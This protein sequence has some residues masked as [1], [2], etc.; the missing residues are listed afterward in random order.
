MIA[1]ENIQLLVVGICIVG[2]LLYIVYTNQKSAPPSNVEGFVTL[3]DSDVTINMCPAGTQAVQSKN[4]DT[5]CCDGEIADFKCK[6]KL[7]CSL[8]PAHDGLASCLEA[9]RAGL[10]AKGT[11]ICPSSMPRYFENLRAGTAGCTSGSR[12]ADGTDVLD[13]NQ[14]K[15]TVYKTDRENRNTVDS[16]Y[17]QKLLE[18]Y[19][20]PTYP[21]KTSTKELTQ[22]GAP[23]SVPV[24]ISCKIQGDMNMTDFCVDDTTAKTYLNETN[25]SW[26]SW[27]DSN[28]SIKRVFC[29]VFQQLR[30]D[31]TITEAQ[32]KDVQI[33]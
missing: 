17:N 13:M 15:C 14:K 25:T 32:L 28:P 26:R 11:S 2:I 3:D 7:M 33:P 24:Y 16:C 5:D 1:K 20:C 23:G 31:K 10:R 19:Q 22:W 4:G 18:Q 12:S 21:G 6:G 29:S 30:I 8:S 9:I 27:F